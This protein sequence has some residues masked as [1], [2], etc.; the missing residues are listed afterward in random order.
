MTTKHLTN[1]AASYVTRSRLKKDAGECGK[2]RFPLQRFCGSIRFRVIEESWFHSG[3]VQLLQSVC[4]RTQRKNFDSAV[5]FLLFRSNIWLCRTA[6]SCQGCMD[7]GRPRP[8][9][10]SISA[11]FLF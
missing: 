2:Q 5:S 4:H 7:P 11:L 9:H 1:C 6:E 10:F 8:K 3:S